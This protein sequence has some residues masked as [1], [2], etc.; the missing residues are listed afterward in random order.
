MTARGIDPAPRNGR[1][2]AFRWP[3]EESLGLR[4]LLEVSSEYPDLPVPY[5]LQVHSGGSTLLKAVLSDKER[6]P[7]LGA[8]Q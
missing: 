1:D 3:R 2:A 7:V 4:L 5:I 8:L 6:D